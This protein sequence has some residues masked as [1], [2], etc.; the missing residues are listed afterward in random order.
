MS[1]APSRPT[2]AECDD[3]RH[4]QEWLLGWLNRLEA[5]SADERRPEGAQVQVSIVFVRFTHIG[6][7]QPVRVVQA[8]PEGTTVTDFQNQAIAWHKLHQC[9]LTEQLQGKYQGGEL[10]F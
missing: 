5:E 8:P 10:T 4:A 7:H 1:T 3:S 6:G 9:L 2:V